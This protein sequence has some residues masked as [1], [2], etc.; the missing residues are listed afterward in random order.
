MERPYIL[1]AHYDGDKQAR[2]AGEPWQSRGGSEGAR[3]VGEYMVR[4]HEASERLLGWM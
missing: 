4:E 2:V 1:R 3:P